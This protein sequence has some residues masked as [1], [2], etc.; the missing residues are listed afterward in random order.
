MAVTTPWTSGG[1]PYTTLGAVF[2]PHR[3]FVWTGAPPAPVSPAAGGDVD[4]VAL[5]SSG[6]D[7]LGHAI[8]NAAYLACPGWP[9]QV[10]AA[11]A[12]GAG[13]ILQADDL[14]R[15][16]T[17]STGK[18]VLRALEAAAG[19]GSVVWAVWTSGR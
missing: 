15:A 9:V 3:M 4:G 12:F 6:T 19:A 10:E 14:G 11:A 16:V 2:T 13:T 1:G 7:S 18:G 17:Q 8:L 5:N